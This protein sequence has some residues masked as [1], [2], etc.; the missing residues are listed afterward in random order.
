VPRAS[1]F[2][3]DVDAQ[4]RSSAKIDA[5]LADLNAHLSEEATEVAAG[6]ADA[7]AADALGEQ[8][9]SA[10][11]GEAEAAGGASEAVAGRRATGL[12]TTP[13]PPPPPP[14]VTAVGVLAPPHR[15]RGGVI[16]SV[17]FSQWTAMLDLVEKA[18]QRCPHL[19]FCRLDG[20]MSSEAR[21]E[22]CRRFREEPS[23]RVML[24]SLKA[25]GVGLNL[26]AARRV[27]LLDP[28]FNPAVE[29]QA[30][31]RVHRLGQE[32]PVICTRF[33]VRGTVE[34]RMLALQ[35]RKR[36]ICQAALDASEDEPGAPTSRA[37]KEEARKLRLRD[38]ALMLG[39]EGE[40]DGEE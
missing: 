18:L 11:A 12:A 4:W 14:A 25:G 8:D 19:A 31:D 5:L 2:A 23:L 33:V 1:R 3:V 30:C 17:V 22:A 6:E 39:E 40:E 20:S 10:A 36:T 32:H 9:A 27:Y 35:E 26:T 24:I 28:W 38:L 7:A 34:E 16:K 15:G 13:P 37:S 29:E 21:H